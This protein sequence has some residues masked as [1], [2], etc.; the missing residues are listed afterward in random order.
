MKDL[1]IERRKRLIAQKQKVQ[2]L[3][4]QETAKIDAQLGPLTRLLANW[5]RL[6][7]DQALAELT[8][9]GLIVKVDQ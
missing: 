1:L 8:N 4:Q 5:D 2:E 9:A 6:S 7:V 3:A